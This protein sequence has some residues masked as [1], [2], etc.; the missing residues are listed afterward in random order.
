MAN[1]EI[2]AFT[3]LDRAGAEEDRPSMVVLNPVEEKSIEKKFKA[4]QKELDEPY[5]K[6][7]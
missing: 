2:E 7:K 3:V 5:E 6:D 1:R 4:R